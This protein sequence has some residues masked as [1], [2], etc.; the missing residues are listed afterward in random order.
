MFVRSGKNRATLTTYPS[1]PRQLGVDIWGGTYTASLCVCTRTSKYLVHGI[2]YGEGREAEGVNHLGKSWEQRRLPFVGGGVSFGVAGVKAHS[3][4][5]KHSSLALESGG[6][7]DGF[8][9]GA[10]LG[11][12]RCFC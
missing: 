2:T 10:L 4:V 6:Q 11:Q 3:K 7:G 5:P 9:S 8:A 1:A 12:E